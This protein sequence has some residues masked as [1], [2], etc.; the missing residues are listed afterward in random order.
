MLDDA[1]DLG[2]E[3]AVAAGGVDLEA[4]ADRWLAGPRSGG[5]GFVDDDRAAR[6]G[7][8]RRTP[9]RRGHACPWP[10]SSPE[11]P[12]GGRRS[13]SPSCARSPRRRRRAAAAPLPVS[14][15]CD[16]NPTDVTPEIASSRPLHLLD[17]RTPRLGRRP[18]SPG[19][20]R[21]GTSARARARIPAAPAAAGRS[22]ASSA[23]RRRA[24]RAPGRS[25]P[26]RGHSAAAVAAPSARATCSRAACG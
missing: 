24:G 16:V 4:L 20:A 19:H 6:R 3:V 9:V 5:E 11:T 25:R 1:D 2:V 23:R 15:S 18:T 10:G 13:R 22:C 14:G 7:R 17:E 8:G 26:S 21:T 12:C